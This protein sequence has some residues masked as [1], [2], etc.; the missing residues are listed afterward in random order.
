MQ[1]AIPWTVNKQN[2]NIACEYNINF[3]NKGDN[4]NN[5]IDFLSNHPKERFN[6]SIDISEYE[7]DFNQ[8]NILNKINSNIY[9]KLSS[10]T[11]NQQKTLKK[12]GIK[13]FFDANYAVFNYRML[14][15]I[16]ALGVTD[17][18]ISD[19]LCYDLANVR[20]ACDKIGVSLRWILDIIPS[21]TLNKNKDFY[22]PW[23]IPENIDLLSQFV[24]T[25]EFSENTSWARLDTLYKIWFE[26]KEWRENLRALYPQMEIDFWNQSAFPELTQH[27]LYCQYKCAYGSVCKKCEQNAVIADN[28]HKKNISYDFHKKNIS[29]NIPKEE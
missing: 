3:I 11:A 10:D 16:A 13:F 2:Y 29:H 5:L 9:I 1:L 6:I 15:D 27:K 17:V 23:V 21:N 12:L 18:Y 28:L 4:F 20:R 19:D 26:K 7:F 22:A 24:D 8:L 14:E 25:F